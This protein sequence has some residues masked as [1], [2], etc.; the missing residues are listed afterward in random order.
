MRFAGI[1]LVP[2]AMDASF[3]ACGLG[4]PAVVITSVDFGKILKFWK[5]QAA[6][7]PSNK[8]LESLGVVPLSSRRNI[9][10]LESI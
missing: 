6:K 3:L 7:T 8:V 10:P 1:F 9:L 2:P 4:Y 5:L